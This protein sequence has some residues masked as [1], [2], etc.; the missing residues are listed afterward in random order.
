MTSSTNYIQRLERAKADRIEMSNLLLAEGLLNEK[1]HQKRDLHWAD[2]R[3]KMDMDFEKGLKGGDQVSDIPAPSEPDD[4]INWNSPQENHYHYSNT[5]QQQPSQSSGYA[6][7]IGKVLLGAGILGAG[8]SIPFAYQVISAALS[9]ETPTV[10][11]PVNEYTFDLL[12]PGN[13]K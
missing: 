9:K 1:K 6:K 8:A 10:E 5:P 13:T 4:T 2:Q 12:P 11:Q 7:T 3:A